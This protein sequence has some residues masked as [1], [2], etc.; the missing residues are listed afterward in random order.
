MGESLEVHVTAEEDDEASAEDNSTV[1]IHPQEVLWH[2]GHLLLGADGV[3]EERV[4]E[5]G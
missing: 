4:R 5:P 3:F 2:D 1:P